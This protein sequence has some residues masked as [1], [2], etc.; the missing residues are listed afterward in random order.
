MSYRL[1]YPLYLDVNEHKPNHFNSINKIN[2]YQKD[3]NPSPT[4]ALI[5]LNAFYE[6]MIAS[7]QSAHSIQN[8]ALFAKPQVSSLGIS[9]NM[10]Y[11]SQLNPNHKSTDNPSKSSFS[12]EAILGLRNRQNNYLIMNKDNLYDFDSNKYRSDYS[13]SNQ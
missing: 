4:T 2:G 9:N 3:S 13:L 6:T 1:S 12:I 5:N 10:Y 8:S 11:S 7:T